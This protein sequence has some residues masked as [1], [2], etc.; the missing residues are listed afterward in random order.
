LPAQRPAQLAIRKTGKAVGPR[1][2][3][4]EVGIGQTIGLVT[5][6]E[7]KHA[8]MVVEASH[9]ENSAGKEHIDTVPGR[10]LLILIRFES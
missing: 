8:L 9:R 5:T 1:F 2:H 6:G 3:A 10:H 4:K 7:T